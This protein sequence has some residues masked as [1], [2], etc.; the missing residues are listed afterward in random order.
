MQHHRARAHTGA[1]STTGR[2]LTLPGFSRYSGAAEVL[3]SAGCVVDTAWKSEQASSTW[4]RA[5][6]TIWGVSTG[7]MRHR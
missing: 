3:A 2:R 7:S 5:C 6:C 4:S 1:C